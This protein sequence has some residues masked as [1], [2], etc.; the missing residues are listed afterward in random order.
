MRTLQNS[1]LSTLIGSIYESASNPELWPTFLSQL[2]TLT[3]STKSLMLMVD[4]KRLEH[5]VSTSWGFEAAALRSYHDH[6]GALDV[7]AAQGADKPTGHICTSESVCSLPDLMRTEFYND[8]TRPI[9]IKHGMFGVVANQGGAFNSVSVFRDPEAGPFLDEQLQLLSL[10]VPHIQRAFGIHFRLAA[11]RGRSAGVER[12][13]DKL[14]FGI[15]FVNSAQSVL[16]MNERAQQCIRLADGLRL[17]GNKLSLTAPSES[18]RFESVLAAAT[19]T[20]S[21]GGFSAG[22]TMLATRRRG[23]PLCITVAPLRS[24]GLATDAAAVVFIADPDGN[25]ELPADLLRRSYKLTQ[26]ESRLT[27]LLV[28]GH[29]VKDAAS[30]LQ[31]S[32]NTAKTQLKSIFVKTQVRRQ[33]ELVKLLINSGGGFVRDVEAPFDPL[34]SRPHIS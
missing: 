19:K 1:E 28:E 26:A 30:V 23:R 10:L 13:L 27:L 21:A 33:A 24:S 34:C 2:S 31:V 29:S 15:V 20:G 8:Y 17:R 14:H 32:L 18:S 3:D 16:I 6:F 12:A 5:T 4:A 11:L 7:W 22:G 9:N 25:I